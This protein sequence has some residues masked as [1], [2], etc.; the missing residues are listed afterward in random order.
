MTRSLS[1]PYLFV[2]LAVGYLGGTL[3]FRELSETSIAKLLTIFDARVVNPGEASLLLPALV[4][5]MFFVLSF[6]LSRFTYSRFFVLLIGA[7]KCVLFGVSSAYLLAKGLKVYQYAVWWFPF[8]LLIC[9]LLLVFAAILTPPFFMKTTGKRER[10]DRALV[11]LLI[12]SM[13]LLLIENI[14]YVFWI[15]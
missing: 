6:F 7:V 10:N 4:V 15:S 11:A 2:I 1:I 9:F 13:L 3:L 12:I 8:Q 14:I 5:V